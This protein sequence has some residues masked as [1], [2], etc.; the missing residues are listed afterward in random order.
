MREMEQVA[1]LEGIWARYPALRPT[2]TEGA[3]AEPPLPRAGYERLVPL[4][5]RLER[6]AEE[7]SAAIR[8]IALDGRSASGKTTMAGQLAQILKAGVVH[9]DDFFLPAELRTPQRYAQP[10]GNVH[11]ERLK[12]E[13][14][15]RLRS[16]AAFSY[17]RFDCGRMAL[18]GTRPVDAGRWRIV[19]GA[20]SCHPQLGGYMDLRVFSDVEPGE[21]L[22]R[23][24][25]RSG[26]AQA[27][28]FAAQWIPLEEAYLAAFDVPARA[29]VTL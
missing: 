24:R 16:G 14:L 9:T 7:D 26:D 19:E 25:K 2:C 15:P 21:Q 1:L 12:E 6:L 17:R 8:V 29:D 22:R 3:A 13:V 18:N 10:G 28:R 23:I 11:Y 20:Y 5:E 4:L 27:R